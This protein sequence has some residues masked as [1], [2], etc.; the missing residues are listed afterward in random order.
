MAGCGGTLVRFGIGTQRVE[1]ELTSKFPSARV[2][3]MDADVMLRPSDYADL[4]GAFERREFDL[5]V[6]TQMIAKGLDFPFVS[7]VGVVSADTALALDDFRSEERTFQLVLQVAGRTGRG[8]VGGHVVVQTFAAD[9]HAIQHAVQQDYEAFAVRELANR[10]NARL[11]PFTRLMRVVLSD[12]RMTKLQ[13]EAR[14]LADRIRETLEK[15]GVSVSL[16]GPHACPIARLRDQYRYELQLTFA[17]ADSML[18]TID[19][20]KSEGTLKTAAKG[21]IVDVDPISLQ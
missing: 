17:S 1:E 19:V 2:R 5:L 21:L 3:R 14:T 11:P 20:F 13:K 8:D 16:F 9:T 6:G 12:A 7:F 15:Q 18:R 4:L 10:K